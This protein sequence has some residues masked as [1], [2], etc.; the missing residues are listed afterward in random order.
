GLVLRDQGEQAGAEKLMRESL[1]LHRKGP[2]GEGPGT[3]ITLGNLGLVLWEGRLKEAEGFLRQALDLKRKLFGEGHYELAST[4]HNLALVLRDRGEFDQ[5]ESIE[6]Q[7]LAII[8]RVAGAGHPGAID[9]RSNLATILR[10]RGAG[11]GDEACFRESLLVNPAEPY[12]A[13]ALACAL[14]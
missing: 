12:T 5:A 13:E 4:S 14:A 8:T 10:R 9:G 11:L 3:A 1:E 7:G 6:R 2:Q